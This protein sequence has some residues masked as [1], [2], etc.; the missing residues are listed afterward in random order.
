MRSGGAMPGGQ[1]NAS[2]KQDIIATTGN[3]DFD[4]TLVAGYLTWIEQVSARSDVD[5]ENRT[6]RFR[7]WLSP[8]DAVHQVLGDLILSG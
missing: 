6:A 8:S 5:R 1:V 4:G 2:T 3:A 7:C